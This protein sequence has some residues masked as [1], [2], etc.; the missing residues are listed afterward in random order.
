MARRQRF[1]SSIV[2]APQVT[3]LVAECG[4]GTS[5]EALTCRS[6]PPASIWQLTLPHLTTPPGQRPSAGT[7][8][9][10]AVCASATVSL[11]SSFL[12]RN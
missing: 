10:R 8:R 3:D 6:Q 1:S 12:G 2:V 7:P 11:L 5:G 9:G 4:K